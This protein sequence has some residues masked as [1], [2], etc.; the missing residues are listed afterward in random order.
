MTPEQVNQALSRLS[1]FVKDIGELRSE[2]SSAS[3]TVYAVPFETTYMRFMREKPDFHEILE[4]YFLHTDEY[5]NLGKLLCSRVYDHHGFQLRS[6][7]KVRMQAKMG[8]SRSVLLWNQRA[9]EMPPPDKAPAASSVHDSEMLS[10]SQSQ[11]QSQSQPAYLTQEPSA[12]PI[13]ADEPEPEIDVFVDRGGGKEKEATGSELEETAEEAEKEDR[14]RQE[15]PP[16]TRRSGR[17]KAARTEADS[18]PVS[19]RSTRS[20]AK[21]SE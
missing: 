9:G 1:A 20:K 17:R 10:E 11:S 19:T 16:P 4:G 18:V 2:L 21:Q 15:E 8:N 13:P 7:G 12:S 5:P 14:G 6:K 3:T